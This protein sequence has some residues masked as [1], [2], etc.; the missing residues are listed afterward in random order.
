MEKK[1]TERVHWVQNNKQIQF[2]GAAILFSESL[3]AN[4]FIRWKVFKFCPE[5]LIYSTFARSMSNIIRSLWYSILCSIYWCMQLIM[6]SFIFKAHSIV[7]VY[8]STC[9]IYVNWIFVFVALLLRFSDAVQIVSVNNRFRLSVLYYKWALFL[10]L[11]WHRNECI[12][13]M[14]ND[15][16]KAGK[17]YSCLIW[18]FS[19]YLD[20][21]LRSTTVTFSGVKTLR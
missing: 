8:Q 7:C 2:I 6:R 10:S 18:V 9:N 13:Y 12:M 16:N 19:C 4:T 11:S 5:K 3:F 21:I 14:F 15:K 20:D 17:Q 1:K